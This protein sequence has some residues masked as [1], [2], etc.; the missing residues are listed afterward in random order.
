MIGVNI[1]LL[2]KLGEALIKGDDNIIER[3]V[4]K[5][6]ESMGEQV[7]GDLIGSVLPGGGVAQRIGRA[8]ETGGASEFNRLRNQWLSQITPRPVP[9]LT[10][11]QRA[12]ETAQNKVAAR[13][14]TMWG[15]TDWAASRKDWLDNKWRHDWR[16]QPR[17]V[18]GRWVPGRLDY[19]PAHLMYPGK[20]AGRT[21]RTMRKLRRARRAAARRMVREEM[22]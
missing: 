1:G 22:G 20:R 2:A 14:R 3:L 4:I 8:I 18:R 15:R 11:L 19:I 21:I 16:S 10:R 12:F 5:K 17:D 7:I 6:I 9:G 13:R